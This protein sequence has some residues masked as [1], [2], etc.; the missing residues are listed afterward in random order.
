MRQPPDDFHDTDETVM[1][2]FDHAIDRTLEDKLRKE[3]VIMGYTGLNFCGDVWHDGVFHCL[4]RVYG[5]PRETVSQPTLEDIM[6]HIC[7]EYG[8]E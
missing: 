3:K 2:N 4:I 6:T 8:Y 5:S 7:S 1:S